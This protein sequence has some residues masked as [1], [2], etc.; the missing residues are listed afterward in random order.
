MAKTCVVDF[1]RTFESGITVLHAAAFG[2]NIHIIQRVAE[3]GADINQKDTN[4]VTPLHVAAFRDDRLA[5]EKLA[6]LGAALNKKDRFGRSAYSL[7]LGM[8]NMEAAEQLE[9]ESNWKPCYG[10][11]KLL[12]FPFD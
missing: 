12:P 4:G 7:A 11:K 3:F 1:R 2:G 6:L 10:T 9:I 8:G 5:I